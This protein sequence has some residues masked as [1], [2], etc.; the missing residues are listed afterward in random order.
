MVPRTG[1]RGDK[2]RALQSSRGRRRGRWSRRCVQ[3]H[4]KSKLDL[5]PCEQ[6]S[7]TAIPTTRISV[8]PSSLWISHFYPTYPPCLFLFLH[9]G[10]VCGLDFVW[11]LVYF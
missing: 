1:S 5:V 7:P 3:L 6:V 2:A 4:R 9:S 11:D 8:A 10:L